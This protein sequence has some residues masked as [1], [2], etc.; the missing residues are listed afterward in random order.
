MAVAVDTGEPP[1][2]A[3]PEAETVAVAVDAGEPPT[4]AAPEA[5]AAAV[6]DGAGEPPALPAPLSE[7]VAVADDDGA[8]EPPALAAPVSEAVADVDGAG[9]PA[10][11]GETPS[12]L[13][14]VLEAVG[15]EGGVMDV[16]GEGS[17][18]AAR[19]QGSTPPPVDKDAG[20]AV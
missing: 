3:A 20:T 18:K 8:G 13:D 12:A 1:T 9:E 6:A 5:E 11:V 17:T 15:V 4:I 10:L 16:E 19:R 14:L 2:I 7:A